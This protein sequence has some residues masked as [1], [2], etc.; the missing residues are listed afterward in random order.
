[1][2]M[3][4]KVLGGGPSIQSLCFQMDGQSSIFCPAFFD[5]VIRFGHDPFARKSDQFVRSQPQAGFDSQHKIN[6]IPLWGSVTKNGISHQKIL[7]RNVSEGWP[8]LRALL[9]NAEQIETGDNQPT[10]PRQSR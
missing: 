5:E 1:M 10:C 4:V 3:I 6:A 8:L 7:T 9:L 2:K